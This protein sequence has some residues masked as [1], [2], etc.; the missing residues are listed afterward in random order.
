MKNTMLI[1]MTGT[2][3]AT[4]FL[5][6]CTRGKGTTAPDETAGSQVEPPRHETTKDSPPDG[7]KDPP[8]DGQKDVPESVAASP[9][10]G[11]VIQDGLVMSIHGKSVNFPDSEKLP[12]VAGGAGVKPEWITLGHGRV[13]KEIAAS[14]KLK[15][16]RHAFLEDFVFLCGQFEPPFPDGSFNWIV[17][18]PT[19][20]YVGH[21]LDKESR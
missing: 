19:K 21:F 10:E 20:R 11:V 18:R 7:Q 2:L 4:L 5:S 13:R 3:M 16:V 14:H 12:W 9:L 15:V 17:H 8:A 1:L 6:A